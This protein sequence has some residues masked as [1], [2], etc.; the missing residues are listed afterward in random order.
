MDGRAARMTRSDRICQIS[1]LAQRGTS[2]HLDRP[3]HPRG[4]C[5]PRPSSRG[6]LE[7]IEKMRV[8][9]RLDL[10]L[11]DS[12]S[13]ADG[14]TKLLRI[15]DSG[16]NFAV[17]LGTIAA[18]LGVTAMAEG[19]WELYLEGAGGKKA[20]VEDVSEIEDGDTLV[21][22]PRH[23]PAV[24]VKN[25]EGDIGGDAPAASEK[26]DDD[27]SVET[28][29]YQMPKEVEVIEI[30]SDDD[31]STEEE[32]SDDDDDDMFESLGIE[33]HDSDSEES[34]HGQKGCAKEEGKGM[35]K[36]N[37]ASGA[38]PA[39]RKDSKPK[40]PPLQVYMND[41]DIPTAPG[42]RQEGEQGDTFS[43]A[44][45]LLSSDGGNINQDVKNR[46]IKLL[47]TGFHDAS[48]EHEAKNAMRLAQRLMRKHNLSQALLLKE[49]EQ[50][51]GGDGDEVLK[52]GLVR[53]RIV[54]RKTQK[55]SQMARWIAYLMT[56]VADNFDV[57]CYKSVRRG[58]KCSV[59]FYGIYTNCQ[60]AAYAFRVAV[61][62][63]SQMVAG[64][65]PVQ[66]SEK[67]ASSVATKR[68]RLSYALGIVQGITDEVEANIQQEKERRE[69][70]LERARR[71]LSAGEAY[72]ESDDDDDDDDGISPGY[73]FPSRSGLKSTLPG[74]ETITTVVSPFTV[75]F[76]GSHSDLSPCS[77][78]NNSGATSESAGNQDAKLSGDDLA[79]R[80]EKMEQ[81]EENALVLVNHREKVAD[82]VLK[83]QGIKLHAG[84][85]RKSIDYD[86][87]SY[88]KGVEDA[89]EIDINQRA[90]RDD[91]TKK[92]KKEKR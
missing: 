34:S 73:S 57:K 20:L 18:K 77:N 85:K 43:E 45:T 61:E 29:L 2:Q 17:L 84:R 6:N 24:A 41:E 5:P 9:V 16:V 37:D 53:V 23:S 63:I 8:L 31:S 47:N 1:A 11:G 30:S 83:E 58:K 62:R 89:K 26:D 55:P 78:E 48:N 88:D 22:C 90:I 52:G 86:W 50:G 42:K 80:L 38:K 87:T 79:R 67:V 3:T 54:Y 40:D 10:G 92:V 59:T 66:G 71:A 14:V 12:S 91:W 32:Q 72:D 74:N 75:S 25:E 68:A 35:S 4:S 70:K 49:R 36:N 56:P 65:K 46:I 51:G 64:Y 44:P 81:E 21:L 13:E 76:D 7:N 60:L 19:A 28:V 69:R 15:E 27:G 33:N 82:E 39:R